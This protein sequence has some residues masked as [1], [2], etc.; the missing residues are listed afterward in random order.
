MKEVGTFLYQGDA[1]IDDNG[2]SLG[3]QRESKGGK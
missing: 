3:F 1:K 2:W